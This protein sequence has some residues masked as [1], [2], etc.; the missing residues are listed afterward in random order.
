MQDDSQFLPA[1]FDLADLASAYIHI[2]QFDMSRYFIWAGGV[3]LLVNVLL[4][5]R[6]AGRKIRGKTPGRAQMRREIL[7]S[8]RTAAIFAMVGTTI[9]ALRKLGLIDVY[10]DPAERGW[11]YFAFSVA[12]LI[13]LHD[14]WFY[15]THRAIHHPTL[16]RRV[17]R[18][19]HKSHHPTP[20]TA[21][22]FDVSEAFINALYLPVALLLIPASPLAIFIFL[23]HMMF[24]NAIGHCGYEIFPS[25]RSGRPVFGWLTTV[26]H[27]DLHHAQAG[28]NFGLYFTW[29]DRVMGTEHPL[30]DEKFAE[31]VRKPLDGSAV[32]ALRQPAVPLALAVAIIAVLMSP[33]SPGLA[34]MNATSPLVPEGVYATQGH[35]A[36]V[37]FAPCKEDGEMLC[38]DM[39]WAWDAE[40]L[41]VGETLSLLGGFHWEDGRWQGGWLANPEDGRTYRGKITPLPDGS[42]KLKG[43]ALVFCRTQ[44][45]RRV[46]AVPGCI[47]GRNR[48]PIASLDDNG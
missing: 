1:A 22:S 36:H 27:H 20:W 34:T 21:Y 46:D 4:A 31:A 44:I 13:V 3:F 38:G 8:I 32:A 11:G 24:R 41:P 40:V 9:F 14:A 19:H 6:L 42:L 28:W 35:G 33:S 12:L 37:R 25:W 18:T 7:T 47:A 39:V 26:T 10:L 16:F 2:V 48:A 5:R 45:W 23:S 30:Y 43:C 17:H 15:W 29:W